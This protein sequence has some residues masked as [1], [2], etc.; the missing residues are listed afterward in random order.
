M[1]EASRQWRA[2]AMSAAACAPAWN[3]ACGMAPI[4][5]G[6]RSGLPCSPTKPPAASTVS[7]V[8]GASAAGPSQPK[9]VMEAW[10]TWGKRSATPSV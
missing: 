9:G 3:A 2:M 1:P 5:S 7:S 10:T 8:A 6:G 4:G